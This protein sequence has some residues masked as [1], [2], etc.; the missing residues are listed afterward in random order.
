MV[1]FQFFTEGGFWVVFVTTLFCALGAAMAAVLLNL[2]AIL[3]TEL[4]ARM[5]RRHGCKDSDVQ[6]LVRRASR[7]SLRNLFR[8]KVRSDDEQ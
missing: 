3:I 4:W 5:Y 2:T 6:N 7:V 1:A 8:P